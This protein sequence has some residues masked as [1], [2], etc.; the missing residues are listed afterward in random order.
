[1][2]KLMNPYDKQ[3]MKM[4]MLKHEETF[5]QQVY[6]L[7]R[8]YRIQKILMQSIKGQ[9]RTRRG[10][11]LEHP[12]EEYIAESD[13]GGSLEVE[14][15]SQIQLTLGPASYYRRKKAENPR[16]SDSDPSFSSSS[17]GSSQMKGSDYTA[18]QGPVLEGGRKHS[19]E[20]EE[21]V[22]S[23][24]RLKYPPWIFQPLGLNMT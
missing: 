10:L 3:Y 13:R 20:M 8:L 2:E 5:K 15:E 4:A 17:T 9:G 18:R 19:L 7:H 21:R 6:E 12:P 22:M 11:N 1:M 23:T 14:D 24:E 16:P